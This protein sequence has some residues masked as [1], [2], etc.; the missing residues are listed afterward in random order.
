MQ[1]PLYWTVN[2]V[3][4][5]GKWDVEQYFKTGDA[6]IETSL[7]PYMRLHPELDM[8]S[9]KLVEIGCGAGRLTQN[10]AMKFQQVMGT[11]ISDVMLA[12]A[13]ENMRRMGRVNVQFR[14]LDGNGLE[15]LRPWAGTVDF[16]YSCIVLQHIPDP[17]VQLRYIQDMGWLL[18]PR[19]MFLIQLYS[20]FEGYE[21]V[22]RGWQEKRKQGHADEWGPLANQELHRY[23][24]QTR[25]PVKPRF[26]RSTLLGAG[27]AV[28]HQMGVGTD[29]WWLGGYRIDR[30]MQVGR[31]QW[32]EV[33]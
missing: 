16:I 8:K 18:A 20:D 29:K 1:D 22:E 11:D 26:V 19:G 13:H 25:T 30:Q 15:A 21:R 12:A 6:T 3:D 28:E 31:H 5:P 10:L 32:A 4:G 17:M 23:E 9:M 14:R 7:M 2:A 24:T 33:E 27:L